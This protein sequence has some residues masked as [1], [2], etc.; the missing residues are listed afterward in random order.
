MKGKV[1]IFPLDNLPVIKPGDD[2]GKIIVDCI[3][4]KELK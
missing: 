4:K 1:E 2:L 3:K